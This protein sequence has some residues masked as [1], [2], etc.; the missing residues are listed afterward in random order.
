LI[1]AFLFSAIH[2]DLEAIVPRFVLGVLLG[3]LFFWSKN[4][5]LPILAHFFNNAQAVILSFPI[6]KGVV[7]EDSIFSETNIDPMMGLFSFTSVILL[8]YIL[9]RTITHQ[10]D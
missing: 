6:F 4:L 5:W 9:Y 3:Y 10:Q 8:L 1:T 2:F 7:L